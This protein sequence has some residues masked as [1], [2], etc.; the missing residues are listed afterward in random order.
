MQGMDGGWAKHPRVMTAE[1]ERPA[2]AGDK[3]F[4]QVLDAALACRSV[5][6]QAIGADHSGT[7]GRTPQAILND[8]VWLLTA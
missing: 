5:L 6:R 8:H 7:R 1:T 2:M 3:R 4:S